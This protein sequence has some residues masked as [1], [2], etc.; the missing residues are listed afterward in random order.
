MRIKRGAVG[1][2]VLL[3]ALF[4]VGIAEAGE[5]AKAGDGPIKLFPIVKDGRMGVHGYCPAV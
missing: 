3:V 5:S 4:T 1:A 2:F